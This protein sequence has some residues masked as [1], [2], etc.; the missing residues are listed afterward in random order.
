MSGPARWE[1]KLA[2]LAKAIS[3]AASA[4]EARWTLAALHRVD[5]GIYFRLKRQT[6]LWLAA[7][8]HGD[9]SEITMHGEG[10][11]RGYRKAFEVMVAADEPDDAYWIG[12]DE[13]SG[14]VLAI[15]NQ[16][17]AAPRV[18]ELHPQAVFCSPDELAGLLASLGGFET[19]A[20]I[21][22]AFP[23]AVALAARHREDAA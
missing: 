8:R 5:S 15:G 23:G 17:A 7:S 18:A 6:D 22:R 3:E 4:Y 9:A 13:A 16:Q 21:K 2:E 1:R 20:V 19:I 12:R 11:V 10:L 14:L